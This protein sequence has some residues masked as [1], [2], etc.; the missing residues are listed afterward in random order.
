MAYDGEGQDIT[1]PAAAD[2]SGKQY[3]SMSVDANGRVNI[4]AT[5]GGT[6]IGI[7]QNKPSAVDVPARV[8]IGGLSKMVVNAAVGD[9]ILMTNN[10]EGFGVAAG[11]AG[12][13]CIAQTLR[14]VG[15]SADIVDVVV[16]HINSV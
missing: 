8:R 13:F 16:M 1:L 11:T 10:I 6:A 5:V 9:G 14:S 7:L 3:R 4:L 2:L 12:A 15:G